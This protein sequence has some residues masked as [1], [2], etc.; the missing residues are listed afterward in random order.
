MCSEMQSLKNRKAIFDMSKKQGFFEHSQK[1]LVFDEPETQSVSKFISDT[2][3]RL[4]SQS[5]S[6]LWKILTF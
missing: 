1:P 3:W 2:N 6:I 5:T 4:E